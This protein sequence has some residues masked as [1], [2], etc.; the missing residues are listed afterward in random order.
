MGQEARCACRWN[1][2]T[3]EVKALLEPPDLILRGGIRRRIPFAAM[4]QVRA[5]GDQL[6]F[7]FEGQSIA[8]ELSG[9]LAAKWAKTLLKPPPSL[10]K[11]FGITP[12]TT[13]HAIGVV[14]DA[15]LKKALA[16]SRAVSRT[17][18]DLIVARVHTPAGL[19]T[20]LKKAAASLSRGVSI[21]LIYRKGPGH[22]L[23]ESL[24]RRMALAV[25][26]VDTKVAAVS[27]ELTGLRFVKR[28]T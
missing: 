25:G 17:E 1:S 22:A 10:A 14:D 11:K 18:G 20:A 19:A 5:V 4:K 23:N 7:S 13:V 16:E 21:W 15:A 2:T 3:A 26:I 9:A 8:L 12:E 28:K 27:D 6:L 24:V